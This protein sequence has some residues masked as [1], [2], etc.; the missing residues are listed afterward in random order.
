MQPPQPHPQ[1]QG[2]NML[3]SGLMSH[4]EAGK[5]FKGNVNQSGIDDLNNRDDDRVD[6]DEQNINEIVTPRGMAQVEFGETS[7]KWHYNEIV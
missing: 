6:T 4:K 7:D 3:I 1:M 2:L 5:F